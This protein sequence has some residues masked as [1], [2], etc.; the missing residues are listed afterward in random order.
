MTVNINFIDTIRWV[1]VLVLITSICAWSWLSVPLLFL[2]FHLFLFFLITRCLNRSYLSVCFSKWWLR[3]QKLSSLLC[4]TNNAFSS[5]L[6]QYFTCISLNKII[7]WWWIG[8]FRLQFL[9]ATCH[10]D[11]DGY[12]F[13]FL[14]VW[15]PLRMALLAFLVV[16]YRNS[17]FDINALD[18]VALR[19]SRCWKYGQCVTEVANIPGVWCIGQ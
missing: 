16:H 3:R 4:A 6:G 18:L 1:I 17:I 7:Y 14:V 9:W 19:K 11:S 12:W 2:I 5:H 8:C 13:S 10:K 15:Y